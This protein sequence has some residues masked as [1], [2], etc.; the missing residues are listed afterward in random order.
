MV[1]VIILDDPQQQDKK[2]IMI[3]M[4]CTEGRSHTLPSF[5]SVILV[6]EEELLDFR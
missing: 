2:S 4:T 5:D 1:T 3:S 6:C